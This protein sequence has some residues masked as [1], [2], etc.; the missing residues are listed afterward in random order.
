MDLPAPDRTA[1]VSPQIAA[2]IERL[3][4]ENRSWGYQR[5]QGELLGLVY[6][7]SASTIHQSC[8][9]CGFRPRRKRT[10]T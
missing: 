6:L 8:E 9:P 10:R 3:A 1:P 5:I 2:L 4:T 7:V